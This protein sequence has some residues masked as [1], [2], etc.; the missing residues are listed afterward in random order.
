IPPVTHAV[1]FFESSV[2]GYQILRQGLDP[3]TDAVLLDSDGDGVREI[4]AFLTGRHDLTSIGVV[5]HGAPGRVALGTVALDAGSMGSYARELAVVGSALG[6][7]GELDLWSCE[8]AG[9]EAGAS[10]VRDLAVKAGVGV[11][12]AEH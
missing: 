5:A 9:G 11:A 8:V 10:L 6:R 1:V 4:A 2:A 3:G 12:A 7:D